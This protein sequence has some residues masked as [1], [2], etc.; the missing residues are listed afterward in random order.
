[1]STIIK[2]IRVN[3]DEKGT[4]I[5]GNDCI[6]AECQTKKGKAWSVVAY[7]MAGKWILDLSKRKKLRVE[8]LETFDLL[9]E[10]LETVETFE[11]R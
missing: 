4:F 1:M 10:L 2:V 3:H 8:C 11:K 9:A 6:Y 5:M 7:K